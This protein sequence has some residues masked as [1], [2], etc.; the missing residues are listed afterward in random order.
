MKKLYLI[1]I[2]LLALVFF[3]WRRCVLLEEALLFSSQNTIW[4]SLN[5]YREKGGVSDSFKKKC[6]PVMYAFL[7]WIWCMQQRGLLDYSDKFLTEIGL[8]ETYLLY[9]YIDVTVRD[10]PLRIADLSYEDKIFVLKNNFKPIILTKDEYLMLSE[11]FKK[12]REEI[13]AVGD[14]RIK[15]IQE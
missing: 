1:I 9:P 2:A 15:S 8:S 5:I 12:W 14:Q 3:Q 7:F 13:E 10:D 6:A 4:T 11:R